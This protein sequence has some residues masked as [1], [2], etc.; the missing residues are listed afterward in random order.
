MKKRAIAIL[1]GIAL[2][3]STAMAGSY[4]DVPETSPYVKAI[5]GLQ[6]LGV[7]TGNDDG[8]FGY[9]KFL[10]RAGLLT[11]AYR[12]AE[13]EV[14]GIHYDGS[15][16]D[17]SQG[18]WYTDVIYTAKHDGVIQGYSD[19]TARPGDTVNLVEA[20]K[21]VLNALE[22][23]L[24]VLTQEDRLSVGGFIGTTTGAWYLPWLNVSFIL[25]LLPDALLQNN[26]LDPGAPVTR[27]VAA[28]ILFRAVHAD[29]NVISGRELI[30]NPSSEDETVKRTTLTGTP[31]ENLPMHK[32]GVTVERGVAAFAFDV[33]EDTTVLMETHNLRNASA[34]MQ[35]FLYLLSESGFSSEFFIGYQEGNACFIR[36]A[37]RPGSY[38]IEIRSPSEG[39]K[40]QLDVTA[41]TGDGNDGF[42]DSVPLQVGVPRTASL[43]ENDYEDWYRFIVRAREPHRVKL[44]SDNDLSC[45]LFPADNV[46]LSSFAVPKCGDTVNYD[47]GTWYLSIKKKRDAEQSQ[48]YT[49]E[50]R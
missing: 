25:D 9:G 37:L 12:A 49:I 35:C 2:P 3:F 26:A 48:S 36:A 24:P 10:N 41:A 16:Q 32:T 20:L 45:M 19:R 44:T 6:R 8:T 30:K 27:E 5:Y 1:I 29:M 33:S 42:V 28:E 14:R 31:V 43:S 17:V 50:L 38:Q 22:I 21:I 47:S 46:N 4:P 34:K 39:A 13:K 15:F 11:L 7:M 18:E 23:P 40:Y